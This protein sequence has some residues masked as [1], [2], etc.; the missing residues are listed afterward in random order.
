MTAGRRDPKGGGG[1]CVTAPRVTTGLPQSRR[2]SRAAASRAAAPRLPP[3]A[4][5]DVQAGRRSAGSRP[6]LPPRCEAGGA[7]KA[8][9][10]LLR[11]LKET[12][13]GGGHGAVLAGCP[14]E[15]GARG[16]AWKLRA[17]R[18]DGGRPCSGRCAR[19]GAAL[20][21][22]KGERASGP[23][24]PRG[25]SPR[26]ALRPEPHGRPRC[27]CRAIHAGCGGRKTLAERDVKHRIN[28][29][30]VLGVKTRKEGRGEREGGREREGGEEKERDH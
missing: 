26:Q 15:G 21:G 24:A 29:R 13:R 22:G 4:G 27:C 3:A 5:G 28:A 8:P 20:G 19:G 17:W 2:A 12:R 18:T 1:R 30:P 11:G 9:R 6:T 25:C 7:G 14:G 16:R 10:A 23:A